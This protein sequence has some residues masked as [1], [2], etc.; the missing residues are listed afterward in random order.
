M[1]LTR[2]RL[3]GALLLAALGSTPACQMDEPWTFGVSRTVYDSSFE[4]G[5]EDA[6][7][8]A[9]CGILALLTLPVVVDVL[10]LPVALP[11][12]LAVHGSPR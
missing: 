8:I 11:H 12:D 5:F 7:P 4:G 1:G 2:A 10:L 6:D 9:A 3:G